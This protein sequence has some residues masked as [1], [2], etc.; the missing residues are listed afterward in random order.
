MPSAAAIVSGDRCPAS[1]WRSICS[2]TSR[3][4]PLRTTCRAGPSSSPS[5]SVDRLPLSRIRPAFTEADISSRVRLEACCASCDRCEASMRVAPCPGSNS[6]PCSLRL[7]SAVGRR[8]RGTVR[9]MVEMSVVRVSSVCP[10]SSRPI[11]P[12]RIST[13]FCHSRPGAARD[14]QLDQQMVDLAAAHVQR[15]APVLHGGRAGTAADQAGAQVGAAHLGG[16]G[17]YAGFDLGIDVGRTRVRQMSGASG[18]TR[19]SNCALNCG[20]AAG[21]GNGLRLTLRGSRI[22]LV[23]A[24]PDQPRH[25]AGTS[26]EG[27]PARGRPALTHVRYG[28]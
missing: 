18:V 11:E 25:Q 2:L 3:R 19:L 20:G 12:A 5:R 13:G 6:V 4:M 8:S 21:E 27:C 24:L 7:R 22:S 10:R 1:R 23:V 15:G 9:V 26:M 16:E 28:L 14:E 17:L